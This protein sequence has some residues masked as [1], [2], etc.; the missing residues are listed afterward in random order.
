MNVAPPPASSVAEA[1]EVFK[2]LA[3]GP[4]LQLLLLLANE[5]EL[6]VS[7]LCEA[8]G[9][10]QPATSHHLTLLR[11][12]GLVDYRRMGRYNVYFLSSDL[13][14]QLLEL[15]QAQPHVSK[16]AARRTGVSAGV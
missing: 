1:A 11:L 5:G 6:H 8:I 13:V 16:R 15:I 2:M 9:H 3:D 14:R 12:A 10:S 4:R 7:A